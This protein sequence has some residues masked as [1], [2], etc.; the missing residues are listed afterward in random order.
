MA[1]AHV[2]E[3]FQAPRPFRDEVRAGLVARDVLGKPVRQRHQPA[4]AEEP[5]L[6]VEPA[7]RT[8]SLLLGLGM[9]PAIAGA[10]TPI[11]TAVASSDQ[12][13]PQAE[14]R[15]TGLPAKIN[16]TFNFD[17]GWGTFGFANSFYDNPHNPGFQQNLSDQWFEG[18]AKPALSGTFETKAA[19][20]F[21]GK[22]SAV[23]E[24]TYGEA[25]GSVGPDVSSFGIDDLAIGWRSGDA[26]KR[27]GEN[28]IDISVGRVPYKLGT[29]MLIYDGAAEGGSRG[30]YWTN[31]RKAF[32]FG[33]IAQFNPGSHKVEA[34]Y[35]KRD[36]LPEDDTD[37]RLWGANYEFTHGDA[38]TFGVTYFHTLANPDV[39]PD[40]D[41][42]D[43]FNVRADT[44][45]VPRLPD[46]SFAFEYASERNGD[47]RDAN[48]WTVQGGYHLSKMTWQPRLSYR[49]AFFQGD[50]PSTPKDEAVDTLFSG[51]S[52]WGS[53][54]Q[55]E[56]AGEYFLVNS[57]LISHQV[58][59]HVEP[60]DSIGTG[61]IFYDFRID[62]PASYG[63]RVT[64]NHAATELDWYTDWKLNQNFSISV[65]VAFANPGKAVEQ[66]T[67]RTK[68]FSY[69]MAYVAYSF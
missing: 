11:G 8:C 19:S 37:N 10:Q 41:G 14:S 63:P 60:R 51:F 15:P 35:L 6:I 62:Q 56:I 28:A 34:F 44:A 26:L 66:A 57:N 18:Y 29:G 2:R 45:P 48:A 49:Y 31:A 21:Y 22:L 17:A 53:W 24:R 33:A 40:R 61:V 1:P 27:L 65:V 69:G 25:P 39:R 32:A 13:T 68:N 43:V 50:D 38:N 59:A 36:D 67:G 55:G 46:L 47:L 9:M 52:D 58:R 20:E 64:D 7:A 16:W 54:W 23:G 3:T 5:D 30:G 4:G 12:A 42:L